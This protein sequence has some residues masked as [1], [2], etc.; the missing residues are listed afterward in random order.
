VSLPSLDQVA[1]RRRLGAA[2]AIPVIAL[3]VL[4]SVF[5]VLIGY[6]QAT[7]RWVSHSDEVLT[8]AN[9]LER[10]LFDRET[11]LR[12]Y[13]I[14]EEPAFLESY[15]ETGRAL[16]PAFIDLGRLVAGNPLQVQRLAE[17][18][19]TADE[20]ELRSQSLIALRDNGGV[21]QPMFQEHSRQQMDAIRASMAAFLAA[22][23]DLRD[24]RSRDAARAATIVILGS[25]LLSL[26]VGGLLAVTTSRQ[27]RG[28]AHHYGQAVADIQAQAADITTIRRNNELLLT[29]ISE[30]I[31]GLDRNGQITF[32][33]PAAARLTG[34][35]PDELL[36]QSMHEQLHRPLGDT[37]PHSPEQ[38]PILA[39][40]RDGAIHEVQSDLFWRKDGTPLPVEY[41]SS[42]LT[43]AET[44]GGA[45][46]AFR[47]IGERLR[48]ESQL[49][50]AQKLESIGR[51][52]GGIAHDFNNLLTTI[53]GAAELAIDALPADHPALQDIQMIQGATER[54]TALTRQ[55]LAFARKQA[56]QVQVLDLNQLLLDIDRLL[57]RLIGADI[58]LVTH[59]APNLWPISADYHQLEQVL[60]NLAVN[61]R[62][63]M[64]D[65]GKL[66]IETANVDLDAT[67]AQ[68]HLNVEAGPYVMMAVSDTGLGMAPEVRAQIFEP[69]FSTKESG[70]GTGLG[71][72][73]SYGIVKQHG[74]A[75]WVYSEVDHGTTFKVYLPRAKPTAVIS[76][77]TSVAEAPL[78]GV[79]TILLVEDEEPVRLLA[80]RILR[81][82]GY[83]VLEAATGDVALQLGQVHAG[84]IDLLLVDIVLPGIGGAQLAGYLTAARPGIKVLFV[85]GYPE[86]ALV[87]QGRL[88]IAAAVLPKPFA[89]TAL[90]RAVRVALKE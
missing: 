19:R 23:T 34:W 66:T 20:R 42:P 84:Q 63:A 22:E 87:H 54:A 61:A 15:Q 30:G 69:F 72:S 44:L 65:G 58:S 11:R 73:T 80:A 37:A 55:L 57:R 88:A 89:A 21:Y 39:T 68:Q 90:L 74:G 12:G 16:E 8:R 81:D 3:I 45:V 64:P 46:V 41:T 28:L 53:V 2:V 7:M 51:L 48:L 17:L 59:P 27:L 67:Y 14:T 24:Q 4:A 6:L 76:N 36:G 78:W 85:S 1:F 79:E 40:L 10:L 43:D 86:Q 56:I 50:Q 52:S 26:G 77:E 60:I 33:N 18:R 29:S 71:L 25:M 38:C 13:L 35:G 32:A 9:Q 83:T 5:L 47:D 49:L 62:D 31:C 70:K 75:L 82:H